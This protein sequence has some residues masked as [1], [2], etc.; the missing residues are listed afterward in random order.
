MTLI[1][2]ICIVAIIG[3][4]AVVLLRALIREIDYDVSREE[5]GLLRSFNEGLKLGIQ[6]NSLIPSQNEWAGLVGS[7]TGVDVANVAQNRRHQPRVLLI[8]TNG[9][10]NTVSLPWAQPQAGTTVIPN[11]AR[12]LILSSLGKALPDTI[13][14][15]PAAPGVFNPLWNGT[16]DFTAG[17]WQNW[18]GRPEDVLVEPI[19]L[20]PLFV[21]LYIVT[22]GNDV[23][24]WYTIGTNI[25]LLQAPNQLLSQPYDPRFLLAGTSVNLYHAAPTNT[26][27]SI[28]ILNKD[29]SFIYERGIWKSSA[30]GGTLPGGLDIAAVVNA[31]LK[32]PYNEKAQIKTP[33][34]EVQQ[35]I[36][37][38]SMMDYMSNYLVWASGSTSTTNFGDNNLYLYLRYTVQPN[39]ISNLQGL[40][41]GSCYPTNSIPCN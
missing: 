34:P 29:T 41:M 33:Y 3:I 31:F 21:A 18:G 9:W 40:F 7:Q 35:Y 32:A 28:Q 38:A 14:A 1:E 36:A 13:I 23:P 24:G 30:A 22:A 27:D 25:T 5:R 10:L 4:F 11:N 26:L 15:G 37:V 19:N 6:R 39:M 16:N 12:V 17:V 20:T 8:D 2:V